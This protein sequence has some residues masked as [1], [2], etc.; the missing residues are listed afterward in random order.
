M[1][2]LKEVSL[3]TAA[4]V[5]IDAFIARAALVPSLMVLVGWRKWWSPGHFRRLH[6]RIGIAEIGPRQAEPSSG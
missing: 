5:L 1:V 3:R 2:F 4:A 6:Q